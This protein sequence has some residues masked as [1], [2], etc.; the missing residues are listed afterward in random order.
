MKAEFNIKILLLFACL[1][2]FASVTAAQEKFAVYAEDRNNLEELAATADKFAQKLAAEPSTTRGFITA[3]S[4][5]KEAKVINSAV[6]K[7][8]ALENRVE[9]FILG[10]RY[11]GEAWNGIEFWLI[12]EGKAAPYFSIFDCDCPTI[13]VVGA[14]SAEKSSILTFTANVSGGSSSDITYSWAISAGEI[15]EGQGTPVIRVKVLNA[16]EATATVEIGGICED[17]SDRTAAFT[18]KIQ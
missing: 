6:S 7:Y 17:C 2:A 9:L 11:S 8:A 3:Y 5:T 18:T 12:P 14:T 13:E 4:K 16:K 15:V 10:K 1:C